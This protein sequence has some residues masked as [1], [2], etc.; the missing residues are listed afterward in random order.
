MRIENIGGIEV[1]RSKPFLILEAGVNHEGSLDTAFEMIDSAA[2]AGA[3]AIKFQSYKAETLASR[4]SPA[5]WDRN[6]EPTNNQYELF[7]KHDSFGD[8]EYRKLAE[9]CK[10]KN[11]IFYSTPF[12]SHFVDFLDSYMPLYKIASADIT[13]LPFIKHIASKGKP[14][15]LSTGASNLDEIVKAV[16]ELKKEGCHQIALMHCVLEYPTC[17]EHVNLNVIAY[18]Q[19]V[20]PEL[21]IGY[22]D[23]VVPEYSHLSLLAAWLLGADILEK[24]YTLDKT[25]EGND[26]YH[27][28]DPDDAKKFVSAQRCLK[29]MLG[30]SEKIVW[31]WE[32]NARKYARR[33]LVA[34]C[35]IAAGTVLTDEMLT[36]KRP[37]TGISPVFHEIVIGRTARA[38]IKEDEILQWDKI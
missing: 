12:D 14:V 11:I 3:D 30:K 17:A 15:L 33:S 37:G 19:T 16:D 8:D 9:R 21:T 26:H 28:F 2:E 1:G 34:V 20:F 32:E 27:A 29:G 22:S 38:N 24:H 18:L 4:N 35:D 25:L 10:Q 6:K 7:K 23:H 13:N 36:A 5:Y 31:P